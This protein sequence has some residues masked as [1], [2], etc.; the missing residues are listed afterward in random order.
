MCDV[1]DRDLKNVFFLEKQI[2]K[3]FKRKC[4]NTHVI[5]RIYLHKSIR[6]SFTESQKI[7]S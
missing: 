3:M 7:A 2:E 6:K 5:M 1:D 4:R